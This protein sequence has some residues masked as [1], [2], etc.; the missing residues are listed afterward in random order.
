[1]PGKCVFKWRHGEDEGSGERVDIRRVW[2]FG[3]DFCREQ[4]TANGESLMVC[5]GENTRI[6]GGIAEE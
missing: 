6:N 3:G 4:S 5:E 1:M 2:F